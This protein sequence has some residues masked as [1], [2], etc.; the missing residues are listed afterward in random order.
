MECNYNLESLKDISKGQLEAL[1][2]FESPPETPSEILLH[3][4]LHSKEQNNVDESNNIY[5]YNELFSTQINS[6]IDFSIFHRNSSTRQINNYNNS[7]VEVVLPNE[8]IIDTNA[9]FSGKYVNTRCNNRTSETGTECKNSKIC[10]NITKNQNDFKELDSFFQGMDFIYFSKLEESNL[11]KIK[12]HED[13]NNENTTKK[14]IVPTSSHLIKLYVSNLQGSVSENIFSTNIDS[15]ISKEKCK[16]KKDKNENQID[17]FEFINFDNVSNFGEYKLQS[18]ERQLNINTPHTSHFS[19]NNYVQKNLKYFKSN[20]TFDRSSI[21]FSVSR[22]Y[23][24]VTKKY[25]DF[26]FI[27]SLSSQL[28]Q[29]RVPM[30]CF[31]ILKMGLLLSLVSIGNNENRP[32]IPIV[33]ITNDIYTTDYLMSNIGQLASRFIGPL[34]EIRSSFCNNLGASDSVLLA[35]GGVNYIGD[36][37]RLKLKKTDVIFK[38]IECSSVFVDKSSISYPLESAI[39][40]HWRSFKYGVKDHQIFNKFLKIFGIPIFVSD[41][42]HETLIDYTLEQASIRIFESTVDNLSINE[43]DMRN[44]LVYVSQNEVD[45]TQDAEMLLKDYF[46]TSRSNRPECLTKQSYI[47]LKQLAESFAK[48]SLRKKVVL[49]DAVAAIIMCEHF[50]ENGFTSIDNAKPHFHNFTFIG[51]VDEYFTKFKTWLNSFLIKHPTE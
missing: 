26:A 50:M 44:F 3:D 11:N 2:R 21:P 38:N 27:Y 7:V 42:S 36:W 12:F 49:D 32:P 45:L 34:Y 40:T 13:V 41:E 20:A 5:Q 46:V 30:E 22:L 16:G 51:A 48:L 1:L 25:S 4:D 31:V 6:Q 14:V 43:D 19:S 24:I 35:R 47:M 10:S 9:T 15:Q 8:S 28:C 17:M 39:W 33:A 29:E 18:R 23:E 37:T